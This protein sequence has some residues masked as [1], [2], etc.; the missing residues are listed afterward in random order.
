MIALAVTIIAAAGSVSKAQDQPPPPAAVDST[1]P[2][3]IDPNTPLAQVVKLAQS[4][5]DISVIKNYIASSPGAF[6]LDADKIITLKDAGVPTEVVNAMLDRDKALYA[7]SATPPPVVSA[8]A[9]TSAPPDSSTET[10]PPDAPVTVNY[11]D[12]T[13]TPYGSWV[14][15]EGYGRCWRPTTVI[16]DAGWRPY[17]DRGHW[18]YTDCGWYWDSDYAWGSTFHY[19][20]WFRHDRFGWCWYP[21]TEWAPSWVTWRSSSDFCGWAPLP[22]LATFRPGAGFFYRG[23][24]VSVGFDFGLR[25]D[26]FTFVSPDH[27]CEP[28]PRRFAVARTEVGNVYGRT[29]VINNFNVHDRFVVNNGIDVSRV[30]GRDKRPIEAVHVGSLPHADRQ[31]WRGPTDHPNQH[32]NNTPNHTLGN[33]GGNGQF[34]HD[35]GAHGV[36]NNNGVNHQNAGNGGQ[37]QNVNHQVGSPYVPRQQTQQQQGQG[38]PNAGNQNHNNNQGN[39][40]NQHDQGMNGGAGSSAGVAHGN[41]NGVN[42]NGGQPTH[43][44]G[45]VNGGAGQHPPAGSLIL[46]GSGQTAAP[47]QNHTQFTGN[48]NNGGAAA[49]PTHTFTGVTGAPVQPQPQQSQIRQQQFNSGGTAAH[50]SSPDQWSHTAPSQPAITH[51]A[52]MVH[53][54]VQAQPEPARQYAAPSQPVVVERSQP[55]VEMAQPAQHSAPAASAPAQNQSHDS[56]RGNSGNDKKNH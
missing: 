47:V 52:P 19:G 39:H 10:A 45:V 6:N 14:D 56:D 7:A 42:A 26:Y 2:P 15:V 51:Q 46:S 3:D 49:N 54:I 41:G 22:P 32:G 20:R 33:G 17:C 34:N 53:P 40:N 13:L 36:Q 11:F 28:H 12:T 23:A 50:V 30:R 55:H 37:P 27:F 35:A 24:A 29:T 16:Y 18:V 5:V 8:P 31:G 38:N 43:G 44:T 25:A 21:D 4:G 9:P 48:N 1:L